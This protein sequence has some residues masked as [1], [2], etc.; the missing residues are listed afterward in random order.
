MNLFIRYEF[1]CT[2]ALC[3][4]MMDSVLFRYRSWAISDLYLDTFLGVF[5]D[6]AAGGKIS[7]ISSGSV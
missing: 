7:W 4:C 5:T 3:F 6:S 1:F 2:L